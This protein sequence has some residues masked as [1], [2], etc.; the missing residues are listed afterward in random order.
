MNKNINEMTLAELQVVGFKLHE[1]ITLTEMRM[2]ELNQQLMLV[3]QKVV[4]KEKDQ[5]ASA[6]EESKAKSNGKRTKNTTK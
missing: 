2:Q 3:R 5:T 1:E 4:E 6:V